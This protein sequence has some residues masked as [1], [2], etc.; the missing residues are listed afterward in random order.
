VSFPLP[1]LIPDSRAKAQNGIAQVLRG[2]MKGVAIIFQAAAVLKKAWLFARVDAAS[3]SSF[4]ALINASLPQSD[5]IA[6]LDRIK[7]SRTIL[8]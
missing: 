6:G 2:E 8:L 3:P 4:S 7:R 5:R 1:G